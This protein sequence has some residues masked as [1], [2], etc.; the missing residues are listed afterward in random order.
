MSSYL[1]RLFDGPQGVLD[2]AENIFNTAAFW[3]GVTFPESQGYRVE[4]DPVYTAYSNVGQTASAIGLIIIG[5]VA[6]IALIVVVLRVIRAN[7]RK[8]YVSKEEA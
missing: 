7:G 5:T 4:H 8:N 2:H 6:L 3:F 1:Q